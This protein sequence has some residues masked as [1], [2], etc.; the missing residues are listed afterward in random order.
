[1]DVLKCLPDMLKWVFDVLFYPK[2]RVFLV[3]F[4]LIMFLDVDLLSKAFVIDFN[5]LR[6]VFYFIFILS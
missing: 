1:M 5:I 6:E 2:L 3:L 4:R